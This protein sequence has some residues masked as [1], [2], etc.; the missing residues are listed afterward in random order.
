MYPLH[1]DLS[2]DMR[3]FNGVC[4]EYIQ[5]IGILD[6]S[7]LKL[8]LSLFHDFN[9]FDVYAVQNMVKGNGGC[10]TDLIYQDFYNIIDNLT[11]WQKY[12]SKQKLVIAVKK[13]WWIWVLT[14][15]VYIMSG[16]G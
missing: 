11:F 9:Y 15:I 1:Q 4:G 5:N 16:F 13:K 14:N 10:F 7:S 12:L 3:Y 8:F 6:N 2:W